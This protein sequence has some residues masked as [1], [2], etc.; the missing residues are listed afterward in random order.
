M[1][2]ICSCVDLLGPDADAR[3]VVCRPK[4]I[5]ILAEE[6][7][8][9]PFLKDHSII[10][11]TLPDRSQYIFDGTAPQ[12]ERPFCELWLVQKHQYEANHTLQAYG[13]RFWEPSSHLKTRLQ[14]GFENADKG[15]WSAAQDYLRVLMQQLDWNALAQRS[16]NDIANIIEVQTLDDFQTL[17]ESFLPGGC[18]VLQLLSRLPITEVKLGE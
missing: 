8:G 15:Y 9:M 4:A 16:V 12:Y 14:V 2:L 11:V 5:S 17:V 6:R 13:K 3:W 10:E 1:M 18:K 7:D